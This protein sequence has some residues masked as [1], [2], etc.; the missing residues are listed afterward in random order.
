MST[1]TRWF[2]RPEPRL[3][4]PHGWCELHPTWRAYLATGLNP[5][6][7]RLHALTRRLGCSD[8]FRR[9][10]GDSIVDRP[11][12]D[13]ELRAARWAANEAYFEELERAIES[14]R[15]T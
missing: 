10:I 3:V 13:W 6:Q 2:A 5:A 7:R 4:A 14:A 8:R 9:Q 15:L 1:S 12:N 11:L